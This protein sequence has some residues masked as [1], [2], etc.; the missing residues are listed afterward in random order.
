MEDDLRWK[1]TFDGRRPWMEDD[2]RWKT[3]FDGGATF[4]EE[5]YL[6]WSYSGLI[7]SHGSLTLPL[8][9]EES[10]VKHVQ[11]LDGCCPKDM[12]N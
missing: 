12:V 2:L 8:F 6:V 3:T 11:I 10:L 7:F 1:M 5:D 4:D 9:N